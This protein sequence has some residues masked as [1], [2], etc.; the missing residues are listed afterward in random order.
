MF[1]SFALKIIVTFFFAFWAISCSAKCSPS[2]IHDAVMT[3]GMTISTATSHGFL[4]IKAG[5]GCEREY[6][7]NG[8]KYK[9]ELIP[10][11]ERWCGHLGLYGPALRPPFP[12]V[13]HMIAQEHQTNY[14][15]DADFLKYREKGEDPDVFEIYNDEGLFLRF[16]KRVSPSGQIAL[17]VLVS[18]ILINAKK[19]SKLSGSNSSGLLVTFE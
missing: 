6:T 18:Q 17:D 10:R 3:E 19:P 14:K 2:Q 8:Q 12:D 4:E 1:K 16:I 13:V 9:A 15:S 7:W 11:T 5:K